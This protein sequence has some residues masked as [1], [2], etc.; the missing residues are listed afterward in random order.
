MEED[1]KKIIFLFLLTFALFAIQS[2]EDYVQSIDPLINQVE[3]ERLNDPSQL[4]FLIK[5]VLT[6]FA[7]TQDN[8]Y[9]L[10]DGLSDELFFDFNVPNAT[11]GTFQEIDEGNI[12]LDNN[13]VDGVFNN[14]GETRFLADDLLRR[15]GVMSGV[16]ADKEKEAKFVANFIGGVTRYWYAAYFGLNP[17]EGGGVI[18]AGPFIPSEQMYDL[19][20]DKLQAALSNAPTAYDAR[21][22]NSTI[23]RI[24]L[25]RGNYSAAESF[26]QN[27]MV[28]GDAP[29]QGLHSIV[30]NNYWW[31]QAGIGR[32]QWVVDY[33]FKDYIDADPAE[34]NRIQIGPIVG[35]DGTTIYYR[36]ERY[37]QDSPLTFIS[38]QENE[39]MLAE[40]EV[41]LSKG[42]PLS[43]VNAVRASHGLSPLASVDLDVIYTERDKELFTLGMRLLDQRRFGRFHLPPGSWQYLPITER[44]RLANDNL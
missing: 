17:T 12:R 14:L 13:S 35:N 24:Y 21:V 39:L 42:D 15:L 16:P 27:G 30:A 6:D 25:I 31:V 32:T 23:A 19:A 10:A 33:R 38:W 41:R 9:V 44:E 20:I 37:G 11:F 8:L 4:D 3:D 43:R 5:G 28:D 36:Q 29:Y 26:A 2:C 1:M 34:A 18:D 22:V 7:D 40:I